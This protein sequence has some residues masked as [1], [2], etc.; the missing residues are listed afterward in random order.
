MNDKKSLWENVYSTKTSDQLS[1]TQGSPQPSIE[2]I[3]DAVPDPSSKIID[4]G[5][6]NSNLVDYLL[7]AGYVCP[8]VLDLSSSALNQSRVRLKEKASQV[9]WIEGDITTFQPDKRFSLWHDRAVFHFLLDPIQR[10]QY[11]N[12]LHSA[13]IP[14]GRAII[15]TFSLK[16]PTQCSGLK[17]VRYSEAE[18]AA[19]LGDAFRLIRGEQVHHVTPWK[20]EQAFTYV[21]FEKV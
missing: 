6:G 14:N 1:W 8:S 11:I 9:E 5:A 4:V 12:S 20:A 18:I 21:L 3:L 7:E 2:W 13:L 16:G 15:A 17:V 10:K 19:E